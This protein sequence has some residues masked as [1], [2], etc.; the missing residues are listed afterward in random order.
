MGF[1]GFSIPGHSGTK[2][3]RRKDFFNKKNTAKSS[4]KKGDQLNEKFKVAK[5]VA[6]V[7]N[8]AKEKSH[9]KLFKVISVLLILIAILFLAQILFK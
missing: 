5:V 4:V 6:P 9:T 2:F 3:G 8:S 1:S 7:A